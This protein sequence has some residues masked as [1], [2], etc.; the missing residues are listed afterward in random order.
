M[1]EFH[2]CDF[3]PGRDKAYIDGI[4]VNLRVGTVDEERAV[5]QRVFVWVAAPIDTY[6]AASDDA[7][8]GT[9]NYRATK[10]AI[11]AELAGV[12][13]RTLEALADRIAAIVLATSEVEAVLVQ[14]AKPDLEPD[15]KALKLRLM[16]YRKNHQSRIRA[17]E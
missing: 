7:L 17:V 3:Y 11:V 6:A 9:W 2:D 8:T 5:P 4:E 16:R 12:E 10:N 1:I 15:T 14:V 13:I